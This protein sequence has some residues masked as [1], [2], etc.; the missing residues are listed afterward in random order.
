MWG[1]VI[2][3]DLYDKTQPF[4]QHKPELIKQELERRLKEKID[5]G[6]LLEPDSKRYKIVKKTV[7]TYELESATPETS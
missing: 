7:Y 5:S 6:E 3:E 1:A 2:E 4:Y